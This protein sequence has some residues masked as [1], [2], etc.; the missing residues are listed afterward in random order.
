MSHCANPTRQ[1]PVLLLFINRGLTC[2]GNRVTSEAIMSLVARQGH[3]PAAGPVTREVP[4]TPRAV[5]V[6]PRSLPT[7]R[8]PGKVCFEVGLI[9]KRSRRINNACVEHHS[10]RAKKTCCSD[11]DW[12]QACGMC[13]RRALYNMWGSGM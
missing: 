4:T 1:A 10:I 13:S 7:A 11:S 6:G 2:A 12:G 3:A 5:L 9:L 8:L